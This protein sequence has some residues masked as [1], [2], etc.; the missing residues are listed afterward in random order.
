MVA[1][2]QLREAISKRFDAVEQI[3]D[4]IIRVVES[5]QDRPFAVRYFD[6][7][8]EICDVSKNLDAYLNDHLSRYYFGSN[9]SVDLRWNNYLYFVTDS[10]GSN[11]VDYLNAKR[12]IED[13]RDY[14]RKFVVTE[15]ELG[16]LVV[17]EEQSLLQS[18]ANHHL[19]AR[20][21]ETLDKAE[22]GYI[23]DGTLQVP[24]VVRQLGRGY[25]QSLTV[26]TIVEELNASEC[27]AADNPIR[28]FRKDGF[29]IY[30]KQDVFEFG[31]KVNLIIGSNGH[32][33]TSLLEAIEYLYTSNNFPN[34][35][36]NIEARI[37]SSFYGSTE[38]LEADS[39]KINNSAL[40]RRN[41]E[42]YGK[43]DLRKPSL[44]ES[45]S[46]FNF[47][48]TDAAFRIANSET[49]ETIAEYISSLLLGP[50]A[51]QQSDRINRVLKEIGSQEK[52]LKKEAK[53]IE[54]G[55]EDKNTQLS[56]ISKAPNKSNLL[57]DRLERK[58]TE[59]SW[60]PTADPHSTNWLS[61]F[62]ARV[63]DLASS[64][65]LI[66]STKFLDIEKKINNLRESEATLDSLVSELSDCN[67]QENS[68]EDSLRNINL[69]LEA[70]KELVVY[71]DTNILSL[72]SERQS[73]STA[74]TKLDTKTPPINNSDFNAELLAQPITGAAI[75]ISSELEGYELRNN[76]L[77]QE[78][79]TLKVAQS[80][81]QTLRQDLVSAA[82]GIL[83]GSLDRTHCPLCQSEFEENVLA[84]RIAKSLVNQT[85]ETIL[86]KTNELGMLET[87]L[88]EQRRLK[89]SVILLQQYFE[90]EMSVG[91]A[92]HKISENSAELIALKESVKI[93]D[94][95]LLILNSQGLTALRC[96][97]LMNYL[98]VDENDF[99]KLVELEA[100]KKEA[101]KE[102]ET[103]R[104]DRQERLKNLKDQLTDLAAKIGY[105]EER[106]TGKLQHYLTSQ[107]DL[108]KKQFSIWEKIHEHIDSLEGLTGNE[109]LA[110][111]G[112]IGE[113][114]TELLA[115]K[116]SEQSFSSREKS[117]VSE[118][119]GL[120]R[121]LDEKKS[122]LT[123]LK[124][125]EE[126]LK[127]LISGE[128]SLTDIRKSILASNAEVISEIFSKIHFPKE[129]KVDL[130]SNQ[131][132]LMNRVSGVSHSLSEISTGQRAAFA[133]SLFL[134]MNRIQR[135]GPNILI[136]D[137]PIS[138]TDDINILSFL[139]YLRKIA[140][141][142]DRQ[143]FFS[144]PSSKIANLFKHKFNF[145][146]S[147]EFK[148]IEL[149]R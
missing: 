121:E 117:L 136:L 15:D 25:R 60:R 139:D 65:R 104:S 99:E 98:K 64:C 20:W 63:S 33:K 54:N 49:S 51:S 24:E 78:L 23:L 138:H 149:K 128:N 36:K 148:V 74:I 52:A 19:H 71:R 35:V 76:Q 123:R 145:L 119:E 58:L 143:I 81:I 147:E 5:Y 126:T 134:A 41:L 133:L 120:T 31:S 95:K 100:R 18:P 29:R 114:A 130:S 13:N 86:S 103:Q 91:S 57:V 80:S 62:I 55:L 110:K 97:E 144:T 140:I 101:L 40:K 32:G 70:I 68:Y 10:V 88:I 106:T 6:F 73:L 124:D 116:Q 48:D 102:I 50:Q 85:D 109:A 113:L 4:Q 66:G 137:D 129:Y 90:N 56:E 46:R 22:L 92:V 17:A 112:D 141:E 37:S 87:R 115:V 89:D 53:Y 47:L 43:T 8:G 3:S 122:K 72:D 75:K 1:E 42:W 16:V 11:E 30:P 142:G 127:D 107:I 77:A 2:E 26:E 9:D 38:T 108:L 14:A 135:K 7:S 39:S 45:F 82:R 94:D 111:I 79:S 59:L 27:A 21:A 93:I 69:Q 96:R 118:V 28:E 44:H 125:A 83:D 67:K 146:G 132:R 105:V 34:E 131:I 84:E 12:L 61:Q